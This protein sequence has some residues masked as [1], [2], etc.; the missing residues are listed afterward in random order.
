M[1]DVNESRNMTPAAMRSARRRH[2]IAN[3]LGVVIGFVEL[4]L[5]DAGP[6]HPW[7]ADLEAIRLAAVR[8]AQ[9]VAGMP[10]DAV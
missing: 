8:A 1:R 9:L 5:E 2:Q 3:E 6:D 10:G 4:L 7:T